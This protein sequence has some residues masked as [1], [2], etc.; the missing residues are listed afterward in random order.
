MT[1][2]FDFAAL[3]AAY[4]KGGDPADTIA[5]VYDRLDERGADSTWLH[6]VPRATALAQARALKDKP[7]DLP[8]YGLPFAIKDNID[9]AGA[10][11]TAACPAFAHSPEKSAVVVER[12]IAAGAIPIGKT[13]LD[14]F[15]TGLVGVRSPYGVPANTFDARY[16]PGGSSS[17]S[18]VAVAAGLVSFSLGTD[19]A[20]SGRVPAGF[21]NIVGLKPTK[22][23]LSTTGLV[24]AC[25]SLDVISVFA[26][27][28]PDA[29][30]AARVAAGFDAADPYSRVCAG[31]LDRRA[32][33]KSFRFG[34][35]KA[36]LLEFFGDS[37]AAR[38]YADALRRLE[39]L[40]GI[41]VEFDYAPFK[42]TA[43]LLYDGPW[44]AERYAAIENLMRDDPGALFPTTRAVIAN[45]GKYDA[46]ATFKALYRLEALRREAA[47]VWND[48]D[49]MA[50]PT[51]G[52]IFTLEQLKAEPVLNNTRLGYYTNFVNLLDLSALA[53]P[54]CL[55]GDGLPSG[56][57]FIGPAWA[58]AALA[59]LGEAFHRDTGLTLGATNTPLP[60]YPD[61]APKSGRIEIAVVG[62][63][64]SGMPLNGQLTE[65]GGKLVRAGRTAKRY[66]LYAL[67]HQTPPKPGL[68]RVDTGT[69]IEIEIWSLPVGAFGSFVALVPPP[70]AIGTLELDDGTWVK[71]FVC[72]PAGFEG[73]E[74]ITALGGWRAHIARRKG[75]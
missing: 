6:V 1:D 51:S 14:Q 30:D 49:V 2:S 5:R 31:D 67:A 18:A 75:P 69:A 60:A 39:K 54:A 11:T 50:L 23:L 71:G 34:V 10:P 72:E 19:T 20:G 56:I 40:G 36:P 58:D 28:V 29:L 4:A 37:E 16:V 65:R 38:V 44:V 22:G 48:I 62:A 9:L 74:D 26:L 55:R 66:R 41:R 33:P 35:P 73:A 21:N 57:T 70:L 42:A 45:A 27:T 15:A 7:H 47:G 17:G 32:A 25:R 8:L 46:V 3:R 13:N 64:L 59:A 52:T 53:V 63:H 12:L 43:D 24:P 61:A 68:K